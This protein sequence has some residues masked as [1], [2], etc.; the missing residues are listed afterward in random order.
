MPTITEVFSAQVPRYT[1]YPTAP[2]FNASV[3]GTVYSDWLSRLDSAQPLSLYVHIPFC[4]TLCWFCGCHTT[5]VNHYGPVRD[6]CGL[7][8]REIALVADALPARMKVAHIHWGGGSPTL[9]NPDD[10]GRIDRA[11]RAH[12]DVAADAEFAIEVD[13]RGLT[14]ATVDALAAAGLT[15][16]SLGVQDC[17]PEVQRAINRIQTDEETIDAI[18]MFRAAGVSSVNLDLLYGLPEQ[19]LE[20][21]QDTL[22]FACRLDPDRL[23]IFG[24]AHVPHFKKHQNLISAKALP[25]LE[26]RFDMAEMARRRL[27]AQGYM[28]IGLDHYA[29]PNDSLARALEHDGL[30]R[31][32]Q[33]YTADRAETLIGLGASSIGSLPQGYVQ[34]IPAVPAY[35]A[36]LAEG[37]LPT[38]RGIALTDEDRLRRDVIQQLMCTMQADLAATAARHHQHPGVFADSLTRLEPLLRDEVVQVRD[39]KIAI[40]PDWSCAARLAAAAFDQYLPAG[41]AIHSSSI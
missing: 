30:A 39:G 18:E 1:S 33:G 7:L 20:N 36:Q 26:T 15:R 37:R 4:D 31:N 32:F 2:H 17:N 38:M 35:R 24:Y 11:I 6:Y 40:A 12:F 16:A 25:D 22:D 8:E 21:W 19:T 13:P 28:A 23:A 5:V 29:R 10:I 14:R 34:N 41:G 9:L 27:V 3:N